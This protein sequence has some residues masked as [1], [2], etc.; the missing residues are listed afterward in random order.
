MAT[1]S[2]LPKNCEAGGSSGSQGTRSARHV[3]GRSLVAALLGVTV[4]MAFAST[5]AYA[6]S[7]VPS[8]GAA[9][10]YAILGTSSGTSTG[11]SSIVGDLGLTSGTSS[12]TGASATSGLFGIGLL[13]SAGD[14]AG[15]LL[16]GVTGTT[17]VST[18]AASAAEGAASA[19]YQAAAGE[20]PT[21]TITGSV[22]RDATLTPGVYAVSG[23]LDLVGRLMLDARGDRS[24]DF[25]FQVPGDLTTAPG[26]L[27]ALGGGAQASNV[28]WQVGG[29]TALAPATSFVGTILSSGSIALGSESRI[30]GRALS[31]HGAV[32][33]DSDSI[34]LPLISAVVGTVAN[35]PSAA[36]GVL[37]PSARVLVPRRVAGVSTSLAVD[38]R[39]SLPLV[40]LRPFAIPTP[41]LPTVP[42]VGSMVPGTST[43]GGLSVGLPLALPL[44]PL[45]TIGVPE[46]AVSTL[47]T[48]PAVSSL[49]P[50]TSTSGGPSA[51]LPLAL[52]LIPLRTIGVPELG[53]PT[54]PPSGV[55]APSA[56]TTVPAT[57]ALPLPLSGISLPTLAT[58]SLA[59]SSV[60]LP[61]LGS[62]PSSSSSAPAS[63]VL[64]L[65]LSGTS[66]PSPVSPPASSTTPSGEHS[67]PSLALPPA[68]LSG[69][70]LP[71]LRTTPSSSGGALIHPRMKESAKSHAPASPHA[72][73]TTIAPASG[74]T[75]PVGAPQTG[76][77][78][79]A[80]SGSTELLLALGALVFA[81]GAGALAVSSRRFQRD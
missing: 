2:Q 71:A 17:I 10:P 80:G 66:L 18:S 34:D 43:S 81:V 54:L 78:G 6:S 56:G 73:S 72:K 19:A 50:G 12:S 68:T 77:G 49:I 32:N 37:A 55:T 22:R 41:T 40:R 14:L 5:G 53:V 79:M 9:S 28:L 25:I 58:P 7:F 60:T 51:G 39:V 52:P 63:S 8:L 69:V 59:P 30:V 45:R 1:Q 16:G 76:F 13:S 46:L 29:T 35:T 11:L 24:A 62:P 65:P 31:L 27:V 75:I 42:A 47:P 23:P 74:S 33:L 15:S 26:S 20:T 57:N 64:P 44:I 3:G 48:V 67:L 61:G 70:T 21:Q 38:A 4:F 36:V